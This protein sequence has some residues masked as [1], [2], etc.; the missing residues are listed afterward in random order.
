MPKKIKIGDKVFA[1]Q[2]YGNMIENLMSIE[3]QLP[4]LV[5]I[6]KEY[7]SESN[8]E[9]IYFEA[10]DEAGRRYVNKIESPNGVEF[11]TISDLL[12]DL[13]K[14]FQELSIESAFYQ[15][16]ANFVLKA[17]NKIKLAYSLNN[18]DKYFTT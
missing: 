12:A 6:V 16:R 9:T 2:N 4:I 13:E 5:T 1:I 7:H 10:V 14:Y 15:Q 17:L 3:P 11:I 8:P 18:L